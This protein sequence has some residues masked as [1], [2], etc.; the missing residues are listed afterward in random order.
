MDEWQAPFVCFLGAGVC[1]LL[2]L[3]DGREPKEEVP[4]YPIV[5]FVF[6]S[7][8]QQTDGSLYS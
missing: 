8:V 1:T 5:R 2:Y 4:R 6:L 3:D 7:C